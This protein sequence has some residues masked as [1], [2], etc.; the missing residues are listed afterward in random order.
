[1]GLSF[2]NRRGGTS[3]RPHRFSC[4]PIRSARGISALMGPLVAT[5]TSNQNFERK[6][7]A[8][9]E[10]SWSVWEALLVIHLAIT[11][12]ARTIDKR[13]NTEP[14]ARCCPRARAKPSAVRKYLQR[15]KIH[16]SPGRRAAYQQ[17]TT[18]AHSR[19]LCRLACENGGLSTWLELAHA[20]LYDMQAAAV[21]AV[22]AVACMPPAVF[23]PVTMF[24]FWSCGRR[25]R[26]A[27]ARE[28]FRLRSCCGRRPQWG[29][30]CL[31]PA[32]GVRTAAGASPPTSTGAWGG[33]LLAVPLAFRL[34]ATSTAGTALAATG[35]GGV[36]I[37]AGSPL[38]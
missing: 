36:P 32:G 20:L 24:L 16:A 35:R 5:P 27:V 15:S 23:T 12:V 28:R 38:P 26:A 14:T 9:R 31:Q 4:R 8:E 21:S 1:M 6:Y 11:S 10:T 37:E 13:Q 30:R 17:R 34:G 22:H 25:R 7:P 19:P 2:A 29:R 18:D 33:D 3:N